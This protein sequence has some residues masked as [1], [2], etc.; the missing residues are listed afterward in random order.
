MSRTLAGTGLLVLALFMTWGFLRADVDAAAPATLAAL[1]ITVVLPTG[2]GLWLIAGRGHARRREERTALLRR[3]TMES[4]VLRLAGRRGGRLTVVEVIGE[5]ALPA[6]EAKDVL[7][8]LARRELAELEVTDSGVVVYAFHDVQ[9][10]HEKS[11]ARGIL[12]D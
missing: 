8:S 6:P 11:R 4:E 7:D 5:L 2:A 10:L 3:Q 12:D 1:L 9:K